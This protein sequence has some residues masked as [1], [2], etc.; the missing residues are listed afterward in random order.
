[1]RKQAVSRSLSRFPLVLLFCLCAHA[2]AL[3]DPITYAVAVNTSL[4]S[5]QNGYL[6][7]QFNPGG[8]GAMSATA[9]IGSFALNGTLTGAPERLGGASGTLPVVAL[10]NSGQLNDYF[11]GVRFGTGFTFMLTLSGPAVDNPGGSIG[12]VF[13]VSLFGADQTTP[14]LTLD[15]SG[16]LGMLLLNPGSAVTTVSF[17]LSGGGGTAITFTRQGGEIPEPA[18]L[19]LLGTGLAGMML[20]N[21]RRRVSG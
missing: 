10:T 20:R 7:F 15:P 11:Q 19:A 1:M 6:N 17:P 9:N 8:A 21:R 14:L 3:A 13:S 12:S 5:G 4:L 2:A 16:A 18:T